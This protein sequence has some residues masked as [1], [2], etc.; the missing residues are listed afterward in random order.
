MNILANG[1]PFDSLEPQLTSNYAGKSIADVLN[2]I[3]PYIFV[4]AGL[5]LLLYLI[6]GGYH[7]ILSAGDPKGVQEAKNKILYALIGFVIIFIAYWLMEY[8]GKI[9]GIP[10]FGGTLTTS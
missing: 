10:S 8:I 5:M 9:L 4:A 3:V 7:L 2:S 1:V 6:Y